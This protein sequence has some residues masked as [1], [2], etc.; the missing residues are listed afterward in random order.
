MAGKEAGTAPGRVTSRLRHAVA[1]ERTQATD[2]GGD[3]P[4]LG[5]EAELVS[6]FAP[7]LRGLLSGEGPALPVVVLDSCGA[8]QAFVSRADGRDLAMGGLLTPDQ[9]AHCGSFPLWFEPAPGES[10]S[11]MVARL[12]EAVS[13]HG[14]RH[15]QIPRVVLVP[16]V[17]LFASGPSWAGANR[18]R[19][20][21]LDAIKLMSADAR[22]GGPRPLADV[23]VMDE[24]GAADRD[25]RGA[26]GCVLGKV[27]L[28]TGAAQGFGLE[29]AQDLAA[30]GAYVALTDVNVDGA[31]QAARALEAQHGQGTAVGVAIDVTSATSVAGALQE[32]VRTYGGLDLLV[33]N[34]GVLRAAS[35]NEQAEADFDLT[36]AVNY[37]GYFLCVKEA[38]PIM[39]AQ[40]RAQP[41]SWSDII[42]IN[43]KSG[44]QG[45]NRNF[46]YAGSKFGGIGLTQSFA[47]ELVEDGIKVNSICPGNFLDG[48]LWSDPERGLFVQYLRAG[49]VPGAKTVADVRRFYEEKVPMGR[50]CTTADVMK[51]LYYLIEQTYE[52]GQALPVTGGQVMLH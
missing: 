49:K 43:S 16:G 18:A 17:G 40:H 15:E 48:P 13:D 20:A 19:L 12:A 22:L 27:A 33:V 41:A 1:S 2:R 6:T 47:L 7:S 4:A 28:V 11:S 21:Y 3:V 31:E 14:R 9:V 10:P 36:T 37:K 25:W 23:A 8:V 42:Q 26:R 30:Q 29:I 32:V 51:A 24:R 46:A 44:L 38:A 5:R 50:G 52:T 35:V 39:A 34:A 45:S